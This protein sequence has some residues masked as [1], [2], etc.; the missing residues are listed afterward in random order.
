ME[1]SGEIDDEADRVWSSKVGCLAHQVSEYQLNKR[2][3]V[4]TPGLGMLCLCPG[5]L[6]GERV[7]INERG[8]DAIDAPCI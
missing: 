5:H 2:G 1:A 7:S 8:V 6:A 3:T 4:E